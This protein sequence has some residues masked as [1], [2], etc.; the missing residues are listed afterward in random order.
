MVGESFTGRTDINILFSHVDAAR[1][2]AVLLEHPLGVIPTTYAQR[3][4]PERGLE[5]IGAIEDLDRLAA[6]FYSAALGELELLRGRH[7][8]ARQRSKAA[9]RGENLRIG[10]RAR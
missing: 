3:D 8:T 2:A 9:T 6:P 7:E 10:R 5:A 1:L 4:G